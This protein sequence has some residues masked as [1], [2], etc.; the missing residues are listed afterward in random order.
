MLQIFTQLIISGNRKFYLRDEKTKTTRL[1]L[2]K[3]IFL[4]KSLV[5]PM[6]D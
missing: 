3:L 2:L 5:H 1:I 6:D 4:K